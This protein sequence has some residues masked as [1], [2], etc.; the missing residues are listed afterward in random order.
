MV[1]Q[2]ILVKLATVVEGNPLGQ[3][4]ILVEEQK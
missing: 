1:Y 4:A 2:T 3:W